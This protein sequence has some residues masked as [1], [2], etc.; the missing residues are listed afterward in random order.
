MWLVNRL[1]DRHKRQQ[2]FGLVEMMVGIAVGLLSVLVVMKMTSVFQVQKQTTTSGNTAQEEGLI[3]MSIVERSL[4]NA[5]NGLSYP[6]MLYCQNPE[7]YA[8]VLLKS[9]DDNV[10]DQIMVRGVANNNAG[11]IP[12]VLYGVNFSEQE[13]V[14]P[15]PTDVALGFTVGQHILIA[16]KYQEGEYQTN[17]DCFKAKIEKVISGTDTTDAGTSVVVTKLQVDTGVN[18]FTTD[19]LNRP[20]YGIP[21]TVPL[22]SFAINN[23][24]LVMDGTLMSA[25][26]VSLQA[27][28]G[29]SAAEASLG[30][31]PSHEVVAWVNP[32]DDWSQDNL[33]NDVSKLKRIRAIRLA[34]VV[35]S[36]ARGNGIIT[37][38]CIPND[39]VYGKGPCAW[40]DKDSVSSDNPPPINLAAADADWQRYRY[41]IYQT[42]VPLRNMI[43]APEQL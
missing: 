1:A 33:K 38:A 3:A 8:P 6:F 31:V 15:R 40:G 26:V 27:Q 11:A 16:G 43:W 24:G 2:G 5:G 29:L 36:D 12:S 21:E 19:D 10:S 34:V 35:R 18:G 39:D 14:I 9:G 42:I 17:V 23:Q 28:Y 32:T 37:E 22:K 41:R 30:V 20:V 7:E 4:H 25:G 13:V